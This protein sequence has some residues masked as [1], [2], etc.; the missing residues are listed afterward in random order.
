MR[1]TSP[2][3]EIVRIS[4]STDC[5][6]VLDCCSEIAERISHQKRV[7][8]TLKSVKALAA[9]FL[10]LGTEVQ[11]GLTNAQQGQ[12]SLAQ[13]QARMRNKLPKHNISAAKWRRNR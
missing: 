7:S 4:I 6:K 10:R 8:S 12:S 2:H 5:A 3:N 11:R 13:L 9:K 1:E